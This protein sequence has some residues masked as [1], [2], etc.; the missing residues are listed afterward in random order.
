LRK[1]V[2]R[3]AAEP[4]R[5]AAPV[6]PPAPVPAPI[7]FEDDSAL[8][9]ELLT[10]PRKVITALEERAEARVMGKLKSSS[11]EAQMNE[12]RARD[13]PLI[14]QS[15]EAKVWLSR[16]P[17]QLVAQAD[18]DPQM[19]DFLMSQAPIHR[20]ASPS[21]AAPQPA[22]PRAPVVLGNAGAPS[23]AA[24]PAQTGKMWTRKEIAELYTYRNDEYALRADEIAK[25]YAENRVRD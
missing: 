21:P 4:P 16:V 24:K 1:A 22:A 13:L 14:H 19:W 11:I 6:T 9:T 12:R 10:N 25:A 23:A 8:V 17:Q 3:F 15:E 18:A 5:P 2:D 20:T 7:N